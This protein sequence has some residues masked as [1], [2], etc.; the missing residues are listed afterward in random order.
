[1]IKENVLHE[2]SGILLSS[3]NKE[4]SDIFNDLDLQ[5]LC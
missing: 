2:Y 1:M 3:K 4:I 5:V